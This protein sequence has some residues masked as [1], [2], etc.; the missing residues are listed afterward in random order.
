MFKLLTSYL[1][2]VKAQRGRSRGDYSNK[3]LSYYT[4][5]F[6]QSHNAN[7]QFSYIR[8]LRHIGYKL[9]SDGFFLSAPT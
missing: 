6:K 5:V 4:E 9:D 1:F 3:T 2:Y 7:I 8:F